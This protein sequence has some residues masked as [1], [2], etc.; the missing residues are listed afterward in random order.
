MSI[1]HLS[2]WHINIVS[3]TFTL[4]VLLLIWHVSIINLG[5][6][7]NVLIMQVLISCVFH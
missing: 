4:L 2:N 3:R 5:S 1:V 7:H 6:I